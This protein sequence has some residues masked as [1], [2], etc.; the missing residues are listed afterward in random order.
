MKSKLISR[1]NYGVCLIS[2]TIKRES[3]GF[4]LQNGDHK[5]PYETVFV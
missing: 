3:C 4:V 2:S 1:M 5:L